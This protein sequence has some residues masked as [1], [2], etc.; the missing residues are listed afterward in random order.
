MDN[1]IS[2][3]NPNIIMPERANTAPDQ[4]AAG[5]GPEMP[6]PAPAAA[7]KASPGLVMPGSAPASV[8][9]TASFPAA[10]MAVAPVMGAAPAPVQGAPAAA[11]E[12]DVIEPEWV[13]KAEQAI[14]AHQNDPY[15][16][17]AAVE[18]LQEDYL[19][20]RYGIKVADP[21]PSAIKPNIS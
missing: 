4:L 7:E 6:A 17:E 21:N 8:V 16:E 10:N 12:V 5:T 14:A 15:G 9:P 18:Q 11:G 3:I 19:Q 2:P 13:D 1:N 20:K